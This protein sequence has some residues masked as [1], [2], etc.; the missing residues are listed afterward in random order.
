M[1]TFVCFRGVLPF[2]QRR[3]LLEKS[4]AHAKKDRLSGASEI[5]VGAQVSLFAFPQV[6][7]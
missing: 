5:V 7:L 4:K 6:P 3:K 1:D 2:D